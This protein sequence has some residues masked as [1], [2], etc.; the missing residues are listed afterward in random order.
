M[1]KVRSKEL[2]G[3]TLEALIP[4]G[5]RYAM[6]RAAEVNP[7][8]VARWARGDNE[9]GALELAKLAAV[10]N[11]TMDS[12]VYD[13]GPQPLPALMPRVELSFD[14]WDRAEIDAALRA[15]DQL[16]TIA[17]LADPK[18]KRKFDIVKAFCAVPVETLRIIE[19]QQHKP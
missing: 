7:D 6:A 3:K 5:Q 19:A 14:E 9:P 8:S 11:R 15:L 18:G 10:L 4:R 13:V 12:L 17:K 16:R 2:L 1:K